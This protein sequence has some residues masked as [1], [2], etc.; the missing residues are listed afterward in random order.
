MGIRKSFALLL[1]R[2]ICIGTEDV[3][4]AVPLAPGSSAGSPIITTSP[5]HFRAQLPFFIHSINNIRS[6]TSSHLFS[7]PPFPPSPSLTFT[8]RPSSPIIFPIPLSPF[9]RPSSPS[10][11]TD[12]PPPYP[13]R[14]RDRS[15]P[16]PHVSPS[17]PSFSSQPLPCAASRVWALPRF[18]SQ[19]F[20]FLPRK[21]L[22][23]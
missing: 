7:S 1:R 23:V 4:K 9:S 22:L 10:P 8:I 20:R 21:G 16:P 18:L 14:L 6:I 2:P 12:S 15:L 3:L 11:L 19:G 17:P 5:G 13:S